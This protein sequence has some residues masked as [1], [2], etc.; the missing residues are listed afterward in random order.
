MIMENL[1]HSENSRRVDLMAGVI[2]HLACYIQTGRPRSAHLAALLLDRLAQDSETDSSL[3][4]HCKALGEVLID[5]PYRATPLLEIQ[6]ARPWLTWD[7][8]SEPA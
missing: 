4:E 7:R 5:R 3:G 6:P 2:E 8:I 1:V